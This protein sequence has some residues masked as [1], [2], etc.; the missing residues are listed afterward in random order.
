MSLGR[1]PSPRTV[2]RW[3]REQLVDSIKIAVLIAA[4]QQVLW[5]ASAH[6]FDSYTSIPVEQW[7]ELLLIFVSILPAATAPIVLMQ[8]YR[9][10]GVLA[11][12]VYTAIGALVSY[13]L[14]SLPMATMI[15]MGAGLMTVGMFL[16]LLVEDLERALRF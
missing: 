14:G 4:I 11:V 16:V 1:P 2:H 3:G 12:A 9:V 13:W 5:V 7:G 8:L 10:R 15:V 6:A